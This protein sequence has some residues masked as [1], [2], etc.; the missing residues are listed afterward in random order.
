M[1]R[2]ELVSV[3]Q[4]TDELKISRRTFYRWRE[5]GRAP[6]KAVRLPNGELRYWRTDVDA[7]L[8]DLG[9]WAA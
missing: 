7:W 1:T 6:G 5:I 8:S 9:E 2:D 4:I 3:K